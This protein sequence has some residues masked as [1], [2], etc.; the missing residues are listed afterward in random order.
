MSG[1]FLEEERR[2]LAEPID[3]RGE[4]IGGSGGWAS[5]NATVVEASEPGEPGEPGLE[6]PR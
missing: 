5:G 6:G 3:D 4:Y 2:A 1:G